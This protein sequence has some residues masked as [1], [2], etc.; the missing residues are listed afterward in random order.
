LYGISREELLVLRK[1]LTDLLNKGWI[2]ASSLTAEA[3][4]LFV[5]KPEGG[6]RFYVNYRALNAIIFQDRYFFPLIRETLKRLAKA[7]YYTKMNVRAAFYR[8]RIKKGDE[9]KIAFCTKF[10]LFKWVIIS[11]GL[12]EASAI[13]QKYINSILDDFLDK[14]CSAY[15]NNVFIY[16][17][18]PYQ[19]HMSKV[20]K[21]LRRFHE[22]GLKLDIKKS[23]FAFSEVRY[24]GFII[25]AGEGIKINP[26]KVEAIKKWEALTTVKGVRSFI[27]FSNFYRGF[28]KNFSEV[29]APLMLLIRKNQ[30]WQWKKKQQKAFNR[31]KE[32]FISAPILAY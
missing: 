3:P 22:A 29:A 4:I 14:F 8:L 13:F 2:W 15:M 7:R 19:D 25:S 16:S 26:G 6:F 20:K 28:I 11:F 30:I 18:K 17:D 21:V 31:L 24:L 5:K 23:E 1:T 12:A 27:K 9:W 32:F 10:G